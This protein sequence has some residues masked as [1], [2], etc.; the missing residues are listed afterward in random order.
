MEF[1]FAQAA[2]HLRY[3]T[4]RAEERLR[5]ATNLQEPY[6]PGKWTRQELLGHLIDSA[7]NNHQRITRALYLERVTMPGYEQ[8]QMVRAQRYGEAPAEALIAL[9]AA[10]N[11]HLAWVIEGIAEERLGTAV[12]VGGDAPV[13]LERLV[14]DYIAHSEHHL[15]QLLGANALLWSGMP[16]GMAGDMMS[17]NP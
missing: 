8:E 13:S 3:L 1:S 9:W 4:I 15:R 12:Q 14:L 10:Y 5:G 6:A 11:L 7:A 16:W 17:P 2:P